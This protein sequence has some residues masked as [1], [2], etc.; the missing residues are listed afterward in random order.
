M[1]V[2]AFT[3]TAVA[4]F[5]LLAVL[6]A[7]L[8]IITGAL[9]VH[10]RTVPVVE[11]WGR[12]AAAEEEVGAIL[13]GLRERGWRALHDVDSGRGNIDHVLIGPAGVLT[14]ETKSHR[15]RLKVDRLHERMLRQAYTQAKHVERVAGHPVAPLLVFSRAYLD[16]AVSRRR[17]VT[18]LPGRM[19][20]GHLERRPARLTPAQIDALHRAL[21]TALA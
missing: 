8:F 17:G 21:A 9:L 14:V 2:V 20:A 13:D 1:V 3:V 6:I 12:G 16:R 5:A 19:L 7:E 4:G 10:R 15:G 18:V 11:R